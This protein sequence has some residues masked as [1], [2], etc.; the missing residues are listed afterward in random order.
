MGTHNLIVRN[1]LY[2]KHLR[3]N[4]IPPFIM[5]EGEVIVNDVPKIHTKNP[6]VKDHSISFHDKPDLSISLHLS[7]IFSYFCTRRREK[8]E[9]F[10]CK[11]MFLTPDASD[12]ALLVGYL[13]YQIRITQ[14]KRSFI[15]TGS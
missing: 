2:I 4:L 11:K 1:V 10:D 6:I 5:R 3:N 14:H 8:K 12:C 9:L 7:R 15:Q 13:G